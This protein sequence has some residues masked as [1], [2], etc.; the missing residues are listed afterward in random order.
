MQVCDK[1]QEHLRTGR[2][3]FSCEFFPPPTP[4]AEAALWK[5]LDQLRAIPPDFV[6]V[7]YGAGG[8]TRDRTRE[9][10]YRIQH[11]YKLAAVAHLTCVG[12]TRRELRALLEDYYA[13][14]VLNILALR[15]DPPR[16][17]GKFTPVP[18]GCR[19]ASDLVA[20]IHEAE[21][22]PICVGV[23]GFPENH[24]E[25]RDA[26]H[27]IWVLTQKVEAGADFVITQFFFDND[28][29]FR[30][31]ERARAAGVT[32]PILPGI[33]PVTK[34]S[35]LDG[36]IRT[37]GAR[38]P[39]ELRRSLAEV[40]DDKKALRRRGVDYARRQCAD[41]LARGAPGIH[42]YTLNRSAAALAIQEHLR[43]EGY[44]PSGQR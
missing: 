33:L 30:Y 25:A 3:T 43:A 7:T 17:Q 42:Y 14:G 36:F 13:D 32:V 37:C 19:Y 9:I 8:S 10:V 38:V 18:G 11:E 21:A 26:E 6:S 24:P 28:D 15:G 16:D 27:D 20:L 2:K 41:L 39:D 40:K 29:Y 22:E 4:E 23:A 5:A 1:I 35:Q 44:A 34:F 31:V 12:A